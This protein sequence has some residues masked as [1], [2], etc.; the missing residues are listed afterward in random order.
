MKRLS[1]L[2]CALLLSFSLAL[3]A[4]ARPVERDTEVYITKT[5]ECYHRGFCWHLKKSKIPV[6]L[7]EA[8]D[9]GYRPCKNC[10]PPQLDM[11]RVSTVQPRVSDDGTDITYLEIGSDAA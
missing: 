10:Q 4:A 7:Q 9:D 6:T 5:G 8:V 3:P 1:R 11:A 2:L